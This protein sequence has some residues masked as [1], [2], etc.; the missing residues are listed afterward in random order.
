MHPDPDQLLSISL[1][2]EAVFDTSTPR[3]KALGFARDS[4]RIVVGHYGIGTAEIQLF[5]AAPAANETSLALLSRVSSTMRYEWNLQPYFNEGPE[6]WMQDWYHYWT[7][8]DTDSVVHLPSTSCA[9]R[10]V[11]LSFQG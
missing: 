1:V 9:A 4:T 3:V 8:T 11:M 7:I 5:S 2:G 10:N 6:Q